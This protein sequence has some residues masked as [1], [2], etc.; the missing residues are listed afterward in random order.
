MPISDEDKQ[1][2][3]AQNKETMEEVPEQ[4]GE[5]VVVGQAIIE[6]PSTSAG[7]PLDDNE[8]EDKEEDVE[9]EE[10]GDKDD[11]DYEPDGMTVDEYLEYI[12]KDGAVS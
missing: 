4:E 9:E 8:G 6:G 11:K 7:D 5:E 10:Q 12:N 2:D 3:K 1:P